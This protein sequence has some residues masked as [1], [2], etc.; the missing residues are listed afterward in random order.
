[1]VVARARLWKAKLLRL[2]AQYFAKESEEPLVPW[3]EAAILWVPLHFHICQIL[4]LALHELAPQAKFQISLQKL[5]R[6]SVLFRLVL[7]IVSLHLSSSSTS[8]PLLLG[9]P[10]RSISVSRVPTPPGIIALVIKEEERQA[11]DDRNGD[12]SSPRSSID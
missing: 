8:P 4:R 9:P 6:F 7:F 12:P 3:I 11:N 10:S 5:E 1:M 2:R